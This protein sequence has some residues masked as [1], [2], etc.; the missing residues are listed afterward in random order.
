MTMRERLIE[1]L[2]TMIGEW[3]DDIDE[4]E[5]VADY[6]LENSVVVLPCKIGTIVYKPIPKCSGQ[7]C[8]YDGYPSSCKRPCEAYVEEVPF[9][10]AMMPYFGQ[11]VFLSREEAEAALKRSK[12]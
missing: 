9:Q 4:L 8:P 5:S 11:D 2:D 12:Q 7:L 6:L 10:Y 1:L 3:C